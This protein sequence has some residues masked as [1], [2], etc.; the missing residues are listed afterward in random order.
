MV[1]IILVWHTTK[2]TFQAAHRYV[3]HDLVFENHEQYENRQAG[4]QTRRELNGL[5]RPVVR[6]EYE[7]AVRHRG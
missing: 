6:L 2:S 1:R 4:K 3:A 5:A 7:Q